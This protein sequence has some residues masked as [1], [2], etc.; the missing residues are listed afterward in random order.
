M[1]AINIVRLI[2]AICLFR[3]LLAVISSVYVQIPLCKNVNID[4]RIIY[5]V[6]KF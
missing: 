4:C 3:V 5:A 1:V 2:T 6:N